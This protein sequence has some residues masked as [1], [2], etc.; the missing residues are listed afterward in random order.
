MRHC[1][2]A[3]ALRHLKHPAGWAG[4]LGKSGRGRIRRKKR[5]VTREELTKL[6]SRELERN[7]VKPNG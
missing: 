3:A 2:Y 6:F 1:W 5:P 7:P 4:P